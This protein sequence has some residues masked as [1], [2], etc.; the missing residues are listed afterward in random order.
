MAFII[1]L[2]AG[3]GLEDIPACL[4][5]ALA[6]ATFKGLTLAALLTVLIDL[7]ACAII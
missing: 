4:G 5:G 7:S 3:E 2:R 1:A 6:D